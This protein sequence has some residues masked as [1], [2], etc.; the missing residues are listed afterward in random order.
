MRNKRNTSPLLIDRWINRVSKNDGEDG[1]WLWNGVKGNTGYGLLK[2]NGKRYMPHRAAYE[3][4]NGPVPA[5][6]VVMHLCDN[7]LC[8]NPKHLSVGTQS[9]NLR[10]CIAKKRNTMWGKRRF[11]LSDDDVACIRESKESAKSLACKYNVGIAMISKIKNGK[12]RTI[13]SKQVLENSMNVLKRYW[14]KKRDP[15]LELFAW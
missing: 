3:S 5:G 8:C 7:P 12:R 1:C 13:S 2:F 9:Q 11:V 10:D 14:G 4:F 15:Q 6:M